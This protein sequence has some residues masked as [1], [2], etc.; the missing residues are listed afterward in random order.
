MLRT[1]ELSH[2]VIAD[3]SPAVRAAGIQYVD[4]VNDEIELRGGRDG[5]RRSRGTVSKPSRSPRSA[6]DDTL[7]E[8][9][10]TEASIRRIGQK[11]PARTRSRGPMLGPG[12]QTRGAQGRSRRTR[13]PDHAGGRRVIRSTP[14]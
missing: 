9:V 2:E 3:A 11:A 8:P 7:E 13:L 4:E 12:S 1:V 6:A 14:T 10:A 5:S